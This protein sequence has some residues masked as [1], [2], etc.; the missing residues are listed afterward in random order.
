MRWLVVENVAPIKPNEERQKPN[1]QFS[2]QPLA[3]GELSASADN[4][5]KEPSL[6]DPNKGLVASQTTKA[7]LIIQEN[8]QFI[9][10][11]NDIVS[12]LINGHLLS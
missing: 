9:T 4:E 3:F 2:E 12:L 6:A 1:W 7:V 5:S 10:A 8:A 11:G